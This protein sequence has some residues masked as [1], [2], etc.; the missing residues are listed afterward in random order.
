MSLPLL[1][2]YAPITRCLL[3]FELPD[4]TQSSAL[5]RPSDLIST[6]MNSCELCTW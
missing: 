5:Y 1:Q 3:S 2:A 6:R 4:L